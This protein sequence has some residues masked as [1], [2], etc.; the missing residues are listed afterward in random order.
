MVGS[1]VGYDSILSWN[2]SDGFFI[3][4]PSDSNHKDEQVDTVDHKF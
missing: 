4:R 2:Q 3:W 1:F